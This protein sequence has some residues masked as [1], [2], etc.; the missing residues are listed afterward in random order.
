MLQGHRISC[1]LP[2]MA[3]PP[4]LPVAP[5]PAPRRA[6]LL[7]WAMAALIALVGL[8]NVPLRDWDEGIVARVALETSLAPWPLK[9]WPTYWG[10]PYL[11]KPP[12]LHLLIA[13]AIGLWRR[14]AAEPPGALPPEW[15]VR[16]VPALLS[17]ALVPLLGLIQWRLRPGDR[18]SALGTAAIALTL[19]PLARHGRL[20]MLDGAQLSAM[21]LLWWA[22]LGCSGSRRSLVGWAFLAG[23][24]GSALLLLKAPTALPVLLVALLLRLLQRDLDRRAWGWLL[25]GLLLGLVP[26]LSWHLGHGLE[27]GGAALEM[28]THQGFARLST[29]LEGHTGSPLEP[30]LEVL[31]G[32]WPWLPF[33]PLGMALAWRQ[34]RS[35]W[36]HW[37]LG[38]TLGTALMVLPLRTQLPWYSL[39]LWPSF[40]LVTAPVVATLIRTPLP[41]GLLG[42]LP[43]LWSLIGALVTVLA[44]AGAT[45][46]LPA[47]A[48]AVPMALVLGLALLLAGLLL[49]SAERR[50]RYWGMVVMVCGTWLAL[51]LLMASSLWLWELNETWAIPSVATLLRQRGN[52]EVMVW[53]EAERPS[54]NWYAGHRV[55]SGSDLND[56]RRGEAA[57]VELLSRQPPKANE[58]QCRSIAAIDELD[59]Y[60][61]LVPA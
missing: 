42:R 27:R 39:L 32:G 7:L 9:L 50:R 21:A 54:L 22:V 38:L 20:A 45:A 52:P 46:L 49:R 25:L 6:L 51:L 60:R 14:L 2:V 18:L 34:R 26:G 30:V 36:G 17:T 15:V 3:V 58:L 5:A 37:G 33:W 59:L 41:Q 61:C 48:P 1:V 13:A 35:R 56:L 43:Q 12:G 47:L 28:W 29:G 31:E 4:A 23:L 19:L 44:I 40:A 16:I 24:A 53:L 55:R 57:A 10:D 8:G 11:N